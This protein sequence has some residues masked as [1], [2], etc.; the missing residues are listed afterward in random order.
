MTPRNRAVAGVVIVSTLLVLYFAFIGLRAV[1]L[2]QSSSII[3]I[4]MGVALLILPAIGCWALLREILFGYR[5]TQL[6]DLLEAEHLLPDD[7]GET[8]PGGRPDRAVA[9]SVFDHYQH[10]VHERP[11]S[12]QAW[13]RLSIVYDACRDR[14]RARSALREA[15]RLFRHEIRGTSR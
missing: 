1:A 2:L 5:A 6:I 12:W 11:E 13:A 7:L 10:A 9:D 14:T 4:A 8:L 3:A 15:I